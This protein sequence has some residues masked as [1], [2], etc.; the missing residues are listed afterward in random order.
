MSINEK[1][2]K[3]LKDIGLEYAVSLN[4]KIYDSF[5]SIQVENQSYS[6]GIGSFLTN[7]FTFLSKYYTIQYKEYS[8]IIQEINN[9]EL[10]Y[11][12]LK[13]FIKED[14]KYID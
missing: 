8:L 5:I 12:R 3:R 9:F 11:K 1:I 14:R 10:L 7:C 2:I 13:N 4:I 6:W